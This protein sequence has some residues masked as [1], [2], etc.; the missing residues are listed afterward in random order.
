MCPKKLI[1]FFTFNFHQ[2]NF[3][4]FI[5]LMKFFASAAATQPRA[6]PKC[7]SLLLE[8]KMTREEVNQTSRKELE[9]LKMALKQCNHVAKLMKHEEDSYLAEKKKIYT[10]KNNCSMYFERAQIESKIRHKCYEKLIDILTGNK[11][12]PDVVS[13]RFRFLQLHNFAKVSTLPFAAQNAFV[14]CRGEQN[15]R[16]QYDLRRG[17]GNIIQMINYMKN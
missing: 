4:Y 3:V 7:E 6:H 10:Q 8:I 15:T 9:Y 14:E 12:F 17:K 16:S 11:Q 5:L 2:R 1:L 13:I